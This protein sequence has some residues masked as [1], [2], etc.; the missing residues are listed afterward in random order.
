MQLGR[1]RPLRSLRS[2]KWACGRRCDLT[3][4]VTPIIDH[5]IDCRATNNAMCESALATEAEIRVV[6]CEFIEGW[7][8]R[9]TPTVR[10][11]A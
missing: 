10:H 11:W 3:E 2:K 6:Y 9:L 4:I 7:Y 8:T 5:A 1:E